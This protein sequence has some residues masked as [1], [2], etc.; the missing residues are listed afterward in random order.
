MNKD[1]IVARVKA[2]LSKVTN[3]ILLEEIAN[4][5]ELV[6][7]I[8][9]RLPSGWKAETLDNSEKHRGLIG[10]TLIKKNK[11]EGYFLISTNKSKTKYSVSLYKETPENMLTHAQSYNASFNNLENLIKTINKVIS[12]LDKKNFEE[13]QKVFM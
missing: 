4:S 9:S 13:G 11:L 12:H 3:P 5:K 2:K 6:D 1:I 7:K 10:Y 8:R